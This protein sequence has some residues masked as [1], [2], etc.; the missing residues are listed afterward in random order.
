MRKE[1]EQ[2][3]AL[4][5]IILRKRIKNSDQLFVSAK[6]FHQITPFYEQKAYRLLDHVFTRKQP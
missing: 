5:E 2:K 6:I 1:E 3:I 4:N